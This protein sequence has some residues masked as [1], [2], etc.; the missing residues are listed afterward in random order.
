MNRRIIDFLRRPGARFFVPSGGSV[1]PEPVSFDLAYLVLDPDTL[2]LASGSAVSAWENSGFAN[3][4]ASQGTAN[5]QPRFGTNSLGNYVECFNT[6]SMDLSVLPTVLTR[7][8]TF[9]A[10]FR[11]GVTTGGDRRLIDINTG[12]LILGSSGIGGATENSYDG[13]YRAHG[14]LVT[15]E[16]LSLTVTLNS[17]SAQINAYQTGS[18]TSLSPV[19]YTP[20]AIATSNAY[21]FANTSGTATF[22]V[23]ELYFLALYPFVFTEDQRTQMETYLAYR[24]PTIY[25]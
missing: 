6:Q 5:S 12:R 16:P 24:F 19:A 9:V 18:L 10:V 21:L 2:Q 15:T 7:D 14:P 22:F 20:R 3:I 4:T 8:W 25:T 1:A 13:T 17:G 11:R 23:G